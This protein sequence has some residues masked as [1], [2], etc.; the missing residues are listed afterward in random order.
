MFAL[1][2]LHHELFL[3]SEPEERISIRALLVGG[4]V[5]T[6]RSGRKFLPNNL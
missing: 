5:K 6:F 4:G 1:L 3:S 2:L